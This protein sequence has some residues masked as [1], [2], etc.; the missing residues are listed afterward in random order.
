[1]EWKSFFTVAATIFLAELGDKTQLATLLFAGKA[2]HGKWIVWL[3]SSL[4][5]VAAATL[6]V[7]AGAWLARHVPERTVQL[8]AGAAFIAVGA[9]TLIKA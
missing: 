4:A 9:W 2:E 7:L 1:M 8:I 5:L 3:A 6:S